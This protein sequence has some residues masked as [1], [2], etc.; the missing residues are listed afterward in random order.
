MGVEEEIGRRIGMRKK[1]SA[2]E[3]VKK[4]LHVRA[5]GIQGTR[6]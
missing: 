2:R 6:V 4:L 1:A 3:K 5:Q